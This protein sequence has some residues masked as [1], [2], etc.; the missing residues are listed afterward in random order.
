[1]FLLATATAFFLH[2]CNWLRFLWKRLKRKKERKDFDP[3]GK[4]SDFKN[5]YFAFI[6]LVIGCYGTNQFPLIVSSVSGGDLH[7]FDHFG[8]Y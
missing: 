6:T 7:D 2:I 8:S 3:N 4:F 5:L 1:M